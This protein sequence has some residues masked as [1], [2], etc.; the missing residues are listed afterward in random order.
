MT[1]DI[2]IH[3]QV[4]MSEFRAAAGYRLGDPGFSEAYSN[5]TPETE[6]EAVD[7]WLDKLWLPFFVRVAGQDRVWHYAHDFSSTH[8]S[9]WLHGFCYQKARGRSAE[10]IAYRYALCLAATRWLREVQGYQRIFSY[11]M[12]QSPG[13][14]HWNK[15]CCRYYEVGTLCHAV[16]EGDGMADI[17][18]FSQRQEDIAIARVQVETMFPE[19][20][21]EGDVEHAVETVLDA[22]FIPME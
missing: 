3:D 12:R 20:R 14:Y 11:V 15:V 7:R 13:A 5:L 17:I 8:K 19:G 1:A 4:T 9:A 18:V 22:P 2:T 16:P 10:M 21:W 6:Q